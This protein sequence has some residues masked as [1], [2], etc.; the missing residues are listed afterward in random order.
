MNNKIVYRDEVDNDMDGWVD[1]N[2]TL[3]SGFYRIEGPKA[4]GPFET[5]EAAL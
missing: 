4:F 1:E 5:Y 3:P 2:G